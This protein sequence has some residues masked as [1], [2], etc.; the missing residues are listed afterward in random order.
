MRSDE[1]DPVVPLHRDAREVAARRDGDVGR[2]GPPGVPQHRSSDAAQPC[3]SARARP[4]ASRRRTAPSRGVATGHS[5]LLEAAERRRR[6]PAAGSSTC[7]I[8]SVSRYQAP[9]RSNAALT[10]ESVVLG[11]ARVRRPLSRV[12][13]ERRPRRP[14]QHVACDDD[15]QQGGLPRGVET[16]MP[17]FWGWAPT[18]RPT[19][20]RTHRVTSPHE[21]RRHRQ[22]HQGGRSRRASVHAGHGG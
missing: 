5:A 12:P 8:A 2:R 21:R 20:L 9:S 4:A 18:L 22:P 7:S 15:R 1:P 19:Q 3:P 10:S 17:P 13:D 16:R 11:E 6:P 14:E